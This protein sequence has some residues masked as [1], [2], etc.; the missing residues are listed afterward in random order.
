MVLLGITVYKGS[1]KKG[2]VLFSITSRTFYSF[3]FL[4]QFIQT[5]IVNTLEDASITDKTDHETRMATTLKNIDNEREKEESK[6]KR[7]E[8]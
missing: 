1:K 3:S 2:Y 6:K 4:K 5:R 7:K 8:N